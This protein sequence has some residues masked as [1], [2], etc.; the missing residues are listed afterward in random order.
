MVIHVS[1]TGLQG[2]LYFERFLWGEADF[3]NTQKFLSL[4]LVFILLDIRYSFVKKN[5]ILTESFYDGVVF[6]VFLFFGNT[7]IWTQEGNIPHSGP[8]ST[9]PFPLLII[10]FILKIV[11]LCFELAF[12]NNMSES[13]CGNSTR[14][15]SVLWIIHPSI[16]CHPISVLGEF[17][18]A[19]FEYIYFFSTMLIQHLK[20]IPFVATHW[21]ELR[22]S[23]LA[24]QAWATPPS[25]TCFSYFS[26]SCWWFYLGLFSHHDPNVM[27]QNEIW[28]PKKDFKGESLL[29]SWRL[30]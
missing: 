21:F 18:C 20:Q 14:V 29:A 15:Y 24:R 16:I 4:L 22:D 12:F 10:Y 28:P 17:H 8:L 30:P 25:L 6:S 11:L 7:G 2:R 9:A 5:C 13:H 3:G 23:K 27:S 19:V 26:V 1:V